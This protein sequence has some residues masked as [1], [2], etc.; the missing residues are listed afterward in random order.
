MSSFYGAG[1]DIV[2]TGS[3]ITKCPGE[4]VGVACGRYHDAAVAATSANGLGF[5]LP[6]DKYYADDDKPRVECTENQGDGTPE[7]N[8]IDLAAGAIETV[9]YKTDAEAPDQA[10]CEAFAGYTYDDTAE[11]NKSV[12]SPRIALALLTPQCLLDLLFQPVVSVLLWV[13]PKT[14]VKRFSTM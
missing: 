14:S 10:A 5:E 1:H 9:Q 6:L 4:P 7:V 3:D 8:P 12:L 2:S 13:D 11:A